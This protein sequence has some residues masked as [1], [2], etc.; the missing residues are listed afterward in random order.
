MLSAARRLSELRGGPQ[1]A[2]LDTSCVRTG[3]NRQLQHG[4]PPRSIREV[5]DG[6]IRL[7]MEY[8]TLVETAQRLDRFAKQFGVP[9]EQLA[10]M[11]NQDWLPYIAVVKLPEALR[12]VDER[13]SQ[14][15]ALD[16]DDFPAAALATL[17]SP[18]ILLTHNFKDFAPLGV[19]DWSQGTDAVFAAAGIKDGETMFQGMLIV[20]A[21]PVVAVG[22][23]AKWVA[24]RVG[25]AGWFLLPLLGIG[26]YYI[27]RRQPPKRQ[28]RWKETAR[29]LGRAFVEETSKAAEQVNQ[30]RELLNH[31]VVPGPENRTPISA[32]MRLVARSSES[33]SAQQICDALDDEV[34]PSVTDLRAYLHANKGDN[35]P[36]VEARRGGFELGKRS[37]RITTSASRSETL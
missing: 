1:I 20:P 16:E 25:P 31:C 8:T 22:A 12:R 7:F 10:E 14:V 36:F 18:A 33:L 17:L 11:L 9:K 27:F 13:A 32:V 3:L 24:D 2:A 4:G 34:R 5:R 26:G 21:A 23:G 35:G 19:R 37:Y 6:T 28:E 29:D 15:E 30:A